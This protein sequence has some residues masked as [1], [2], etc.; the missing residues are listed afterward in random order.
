MC[1]LYTCV[2]IC[3]LL[4]IHVVES[5]IELSYRLDRNPRKSPLKPV[6]CFWI[7]VSLAISEVTA[8]VLLLLWKLLKLCIRIWKRN[9]RLWDYSLPHKKVYV[10]LSSLVLKTEEGRWKV[11]D[12]A[13]T[14]LIWSKLGQASFWN[15]KKWGLVQFGPTQ[16]F[17]PSFW[18]LA[19]NASVYFLLVET[20]PS[21]SI[22]P[23][24]SPTLFLQDVYYSY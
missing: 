22:V 1:A 16:W 8:F 12:A 5:A 9:P 11:G 15:S 3:A 21:C 17:S 4:P 20:V 19:L 13:H 24:S 18:V 7:W 23:P 2:Q 6:F 14:P 10:L